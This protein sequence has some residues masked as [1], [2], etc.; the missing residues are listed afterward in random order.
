MTSGGD[1]ADRIVPIG[2]PAVDAAID[3]ANEALRK[4][5]RDHGEEQTGLPRPPSAPP[6]EGSAPFGADGVDDGDAPNAA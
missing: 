6:A 5:L 2:G 1:K 3:E 4:L